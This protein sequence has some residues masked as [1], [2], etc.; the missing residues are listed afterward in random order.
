MPFVVVVIGKDTIM[1]VVA[2]YLSPLPAAI[3]LYGVLDS[4]A[5]HMRT[6]DLSAQI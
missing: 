3:S 1:Q 2:Y 5:V 6:V 4:S